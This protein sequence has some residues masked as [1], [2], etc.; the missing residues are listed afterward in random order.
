MNKNQP[1]VGATVM[2]NLSAALG[3]LRRRVSKTKLVFHCR[4]VKLPS[5]HADLV[6]FLATFIYDIAF[7]PKNCNPTPSQRIDAVTLDLHELLHELDDIEKM[8]K[9]GKNLGSKVAEQRRSILSSLMRLEELAAPGLRRPSKK[10]A[11]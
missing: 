8:P 1:S 6:S 9:I 7:E 4:L 5:Q 10:R 11:G 3:E 2:P